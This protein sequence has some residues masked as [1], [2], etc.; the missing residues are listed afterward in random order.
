MRA[1]VLLHGLGRTEWSPCAIHFA[2]SGSLSASQGSARVQFRKFLRQS[3]CSDTTFRTPVRV[4]H[5]LATALAN[6]S[7]AYV[8]HDQ[9]GLAGDG[10]AGP[11]EVVP[12]VE[13]VPVARL[14]VWAGSA[15]AKARGDCSWVLD[16]LGKLYY[17]RHSRR[18]PTS[19]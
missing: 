11:L 12:H 8:L 1:L 9:L 6:D 7:V 15:G 5:M 16:S 14:M 17:G 10:Q 19:T 3:G 4:Q 2:G 18:V 13:D